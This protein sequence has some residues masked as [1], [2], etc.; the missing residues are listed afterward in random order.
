MQAAYVYQPS[1]KVHVFDATLLPWQAT[2]EPG[3]RLKPVRYDD[4]LQVLAAADSACYAAKD[5]QYYRPSRE[6]KLFRASAL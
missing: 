6:N 4:E 2:P 1:G 5:T 3:L